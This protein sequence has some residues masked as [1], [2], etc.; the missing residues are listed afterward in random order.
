MPCSAIVVAA[1]AVEGVDTVTVSLVSEYNETAHIK[2]YYYKEWV[3]WDDNDTKFET[4]RIKCMLKEDEE[5]G[6][7][8]GDIII[9]PSELWVLQGGFKDRFNQYYA[10]GLSDGLGCV[11][12]LFI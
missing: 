7:N 1:D 10:N 3:E 11:N 4:K 5:L 6:I 12:V 2:R 8:N 9:G